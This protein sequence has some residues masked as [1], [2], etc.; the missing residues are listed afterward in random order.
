MS[1]RRFSP[2]S[3]VPVFQKASRWARPN[4]PLTSPLSF[5]PSASALHVPFSDHAPPWRDSF[6]ATDTSWLR[7][8]PSFGTH[9][10][11]LITTASLPEMPSS[12]TF[13]P[14]G[15]TTCRPAL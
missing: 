11:G 6:A 3:H 14:V 2:S 5:W 15:S 9:W 8:L 4:V 12:L 13:S 10:S 7:S 1:N